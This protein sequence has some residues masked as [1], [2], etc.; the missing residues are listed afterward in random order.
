MKKFSKVFLSLLL[1]VFSVVSLCACSGGEQKETTPTE[2]AKFSIGCIRTDDTEEAKRAYEGFVRAF[3]EKG[4][5]EHDYYDIAIADCDNSKEKCKSAA[6]KFVKDKVDLIFTFGEEATLAA[7]NATKDIPVIFCGVA[8]P[9]ESGI[10]KSCE[11]PDANVTGVSD[12]APV[13]GQ[14]EF[15]KKVLPDAKSVN[16]LYMSTDANSILISTLA[17]EEAEGLG[18]KYSTYAVADKKQ[19]EKVLP[20]IFEDTDALYLC[21]DEV[22]LENADKIIK[23][24][25][26]AKIPIFAVTKSFMSFGT[27]ATCLPDYEDLGFNAGELAL[28]CLKELHPISN[29]SVEYPVKCI[30]YV[31]ESVANELE[32]KV[33]ASDT[34]QLLK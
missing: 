29:I 34:L 25:N 23:A 33:E 12:F 28:I 19:L 18:I 15:I 8:D 10:M 24:A 16:A 21:E 2:P 20:D 3:T 9:I 30:G 14:F 31:S 27:F 1:V 6:E 7:K 17:K 22:T 13:K 5:A 11:K 4:Y 32:I 26:K